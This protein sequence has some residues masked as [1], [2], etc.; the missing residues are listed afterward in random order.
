MNWNAIIVSLGLLVAA[1]V[2]MSRASE[3]RHE[4]TVR[5]IQRNVTTIRTGRLM[6]EGRDIVCELGGE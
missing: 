5:D 1:V 2:G 3:P 6:Y 4:C